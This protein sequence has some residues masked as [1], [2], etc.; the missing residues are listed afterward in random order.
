MPSD[1]FNHLFNWAE[2]DFFQMLC[3]LKVVWS[4]FLSLAVMIVPANN[5][6][7][8]RVHQQ[9]VAR[10]RPAN[11][12]PPFLRSIFSERIPLICSLLAFAHMLPDASSPLPSPSSRALLLIFYNLTI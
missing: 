12:F 9:L 8:W 1:F 10:S 6:R 11:L 5:G 3:L 2:R 7:I 4:A